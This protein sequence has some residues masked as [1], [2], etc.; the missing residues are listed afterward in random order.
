[1]LKPRPMNTTRRERIA[2]LSV[3][4]NAQDVFLI[5]TGV[6][7]AAIGLKCFLLPNGFLDG[8]VTGISLLINRL[9]GISKPPYSRTTNC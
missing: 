1:M 9:T 4:Q 8:G 5:A 3:I 2:R 7:L 6:M